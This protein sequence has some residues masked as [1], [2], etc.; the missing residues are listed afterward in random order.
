MSAEKQAIFSQMRARTQ[1]N[2]A[3]QR[4]R[5]DEPPTALYPICDPCVAGEGSEC[6]TPGC[7]L[8]MRDVPPDGLVKEF[9]QP[10]LD[11]EQAVE[12]AARAKFPGDVPW[13]YEKTDPLAAADCERYRNH[14][15][16][17]VLAALDG[18]S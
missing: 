7:A 9:R 11:V 18:A 2:I 5:D 12:R 17:I 14:V 4:T 6:H 10:D 16:P 13:L 8:F 15:R 3:R 1:E